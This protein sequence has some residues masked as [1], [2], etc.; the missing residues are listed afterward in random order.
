MIFEKIKSEI[1]AGTIIPQPISDGYQ[2]KG[3]G[4]SRG[5]EALVY[6]I[7]N[8]NNPNS[9]NTKRVPKSDWEEAYEYLKDHGKLTREWFEKNTI[10]AKDGG[11]NFT[12]I[13]GVFSFLCIAEYN[14]DGYYVKAKKL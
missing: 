14:E 9:P 2:V 8:R 10:C 5:Q 4:K 7:P 6:L 3:Y 11:C 1:S 12:V 13:G